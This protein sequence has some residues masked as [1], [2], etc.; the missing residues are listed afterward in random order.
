MNPDVMG[1]LLGMAMVTF[2]PRFFPMAFLT[3]VA[4]P[5]KMKIALDYIP[6][7]ILSAIVFPILLP[8]GGGS[9][10][11]EPRVLL[12]AIPVCLFAYKMK[13]LWGSVVL[14]M[15]VY[16]GIGGFF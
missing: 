15:A 7:A 6:V 2:L 5:E 16:W 3:R 10:G 4:I 9:L 8:G 1:L 12:S 11:I 14:G 13:N